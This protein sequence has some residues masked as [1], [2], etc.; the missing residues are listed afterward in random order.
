M[1]KSLNLERAYLRG[2]FG[3]IPDVDQVDVHRALGFP[4]DKG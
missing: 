1:R 2:R 3:A 4:A